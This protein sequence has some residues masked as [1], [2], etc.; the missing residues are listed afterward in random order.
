MNISLLGDWFDN[1]VNF[2]VGFFAFIP[3]VIYFLYASIASLLD[4]LQSLLRKLAGLDVY[5]VNGQAQSGDILYEFIQGILGI[6]NDSSYSI[7]ST[8]FWS[9]V[10]FGVILLIL[11]T[12]VSIIK[13]HY[14]Y[15]A[16]N[17][18]PLKIFYS[19]LKSFSLIVIVPIVSLLGIM[20][21]QILL[22]TVD[23]IT[24]SASSSSI[25]D[26]FSTTTVNSE[27][28]EAQKVSFAREKFE[29]GTS[30]TGYETYARYDFFS[31]GDYTTSS[32]FSGMLFNIAAYSCN[33]VRLG[34]YSV[35]TA[36]GDD[37]WDNQGVFYVSNSSDREALATQIDYAFVNN[38]KLKN[39]NAKEN[40]ITIDGK[41]SAFLGP[42]FAFG[43]SAAV[44]LQLINVRSFSKFNVGAVYYYYDLWAFN[45]LLGFAG[46]II[47]ATLLGNIVF[48]LI[49]RL[50]QVVALFLV[51]PALI[52][53]M[54]L[55]SG[56]AFGSWRKQFISDILM[57]FGAVVGM[58]IF[59][60]ILPFFQTISFFNIKL[61]D[62]IVNMVIVLAG[63]TLV[64]K[65]ISLTSKF[66]GGSDANETGQAVMADVKNTAMKGLAGA[67]TLAGVGAATF[68]PVAGMMRH[69]AGLIKRGASSVGTKVADAY[70]RKHDPSLDTK[71]KRE[72]A[73]EDNKIR[74][75]LG[76]AD[77]A[78]ISDRD[79]K[80]YEDYKKLDRKGKRD[81]RAILKPGPFSL[82]VG[83]DPSGSARDRDALTDEIERAKAD[84]ASRAETKRLKRIDKNTKKINRKYIGAQIG[85]VLTGKDPREVKKGVVDATTGEITDSGS[86]GALRA[87]GTAFVDFSQVAIEATSKL[88]GASSAWKQLGESGA[89]DS[90]KKALR[91]VTEGLGFTTLSNAGAL[92]TKKEKDDKESSRSKAVRDD[93]VRAMRELVSATEKN[94]QQVQELI[95]TLRVPR[96][97]GGTP[98]TG[99][100]HP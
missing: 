93:Q 24:T 97:G 52:G 7:L 32:T 56:S 1:L 55:D 8:I 9:F 72:K 58:N 59:F 35:L 99:G 17:S 30:S 69:G 12:I 39:D 57:A 71:E 23:R 81:V 36:P 21:A 26:V 49:A 68:V 85:A 40:N 88:S 47:A 91:R 92:L 61:V 67:L 38:L 41:E 6:N 89:I 62:N 22:Q 48:G 53:I 76:L 100:S 2:I 96:G 42:A 28:N 64:K 90:A 66:V 78:V 54:P 84:T 14:N 13:A 5:Y 16:N 87:F 34:H 82:G 25:D 50:L 27:T 33:R 37:L 60:S 95:N 44:G 15:D 77:G 75:T 31:Y 63:L 18:H 43:Y 98:P 46:I 65:F 10:I 73:R 29:T 3:Q 80:E 45:Y 94:S 79:R 4:L 11:S 83:L 74:K 51:F 70:Y 20:L 86:G 19:S